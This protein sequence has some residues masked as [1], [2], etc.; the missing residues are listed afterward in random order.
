MCH[1]RAKSLTSDTR[2]PDIVNKE[3][4]LQNMLSINAEVE[5]FI[6]VDLVIRREEFE[7]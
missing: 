2:T 5:S 7:T 6:L 1:K 3:I 4:S